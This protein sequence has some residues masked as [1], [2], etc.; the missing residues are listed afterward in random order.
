MSVVPALETPPPAPS[1]ALGAI[2]HAASDVPAAMACPAAQARVLIGGEIR[3]WDGTKRDVVSPLWL[4][5]AADAAPTP[6]ILGQTP[7]LT[8]DV[9]LEA[10]AAARSAWAQGAGPWPTLRVEARIEAVERFLAA[11]VAVRDRVC[12]LLMWEVGKTWPD[13]QSEF[14]RTVQYLRD[15]VEAL[16]TQD[17]DNSRL[18]FRE[19][20]IAQVR[21]APL[22]VC[23]TT[24][25]RDEDGTR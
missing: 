2:F 4:R 12:R 24:S 18:Q 19:G 14:D 20:V 23:A 16:K 22:G 5:P 8:A 21:R 13:A 1:S 9:A 25:S 7:H 17:R 15:T 3:T 11:M 6:T 10:L